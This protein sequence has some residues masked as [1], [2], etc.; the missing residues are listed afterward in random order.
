MRKKNYLFNRF[1]IVLV[2][3]ATFFYIF[4]I[5]DKPI[6]ALPE[7][8]YDDGLF[9]RSLESIL[10]GEWLGKYDN[11]TLAKGPMLSMVGAFSTVFGVK[12]KIA[13]AIIY[14]I[15]ASALFL[16]ARRIGMHLVAAAALFVFI[17]FN[18]YLYVG[19]NINPYLYVG[20]NRFVRDF[21][22]TAFVMLTFF[23]AVG[24]I[25]R[26]HK[27]AGIWFAVGT[28]FFAGCAF[29]TREEDIWIIAILTT[30]FLT[31]TLIAIVRTR[32]SLI[33]E[34]W[35]S[36]AHRAFV[37]TLAFAAIVLPV[38]LANHLAYGNAIVSEFRSSEFRAAI[39]ALARVGNIHP[40]GYVPVPQ[41]SL[42]AV[43]KVAPVT[44]S[45]RDH[46]PKVTA[47]WSIPSRE[48]A[49]EFPN[50]V[51]GGFFA[52][53]FRDAA[54]AAGHHSSASAARD[55]YAQLANEV[56]GACD[57]GALTC[58]GKRASVAPELTLERLPSLIKASWNAL[59]YTV[60]MK[61]G[62]VKPARSKGE[63]AILMRWNQLIGPVVVDA[64][65]Q[66]LISGWV[67]NMNGNQPFIAAGTDSSIQIRD[68]SIGSGMDVVKHFNK[69]GIKEVEAIR[70]S[71][72]MNCLD[73]SCAVSV[74]TSKGERQKIPLDRLVHG[75]NGKIPLESPYVGHFDVVNKHTS[76]NLSPHRLEDLKF[77]ITSSAVKFVQ[78]IIPILV[79]IA[80][81]GIFLYL[82]RCSQY[83][84]SDWLFILAVGAATAVIMRSIIIAYIDISSWRAI[85]SIY[86][87][88][89]YCFV[90]IYSIAGTNIAINILYDYFRSYSS[91]R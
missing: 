91:S 39:G 83:K 52:W 37:A 2:A 67:A 1:C 49:P 61:G 28:G 55:F 75:R 31:T 19:D 79:I 45:I 35:K 48:V 25:S 63:T 77:Y 88:P 6:T 16:I 47:N 33:I 11:R 69:Q 60:A 72:I 3:I 46:W 71:L 59:F 38:A 34:K 76:S 42:E 89:A 4:I 8:G 40:S 64:Q 9:F 73:D 22:Y 5:T 43:F 21:L 14:L 87:G 7:W 80:T 12:A 27:R 74:M 41:S 85:N 10:K 15:A 58:R 57:E 24:A 50:E 62:Q 30:L 78:V 44:T 18:P 54:A 13:E 84:R 53:A 90:I 51:K 82:I 86:L 26:E 66:F 29:L 36:G 81:I 56:N 70:F 17:L 65:N 68:L 20:G 32:L 23:F